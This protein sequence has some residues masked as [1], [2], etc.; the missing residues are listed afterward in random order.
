MNRSRTI[1]ELLGF[2]EQAEAKLLSWGFYD[3]SFSPSELEELVENEAPLELLEAVHQL[4]REGTEK[5][6][7]LL[8]EMQFGKLLFETSNR[9]RRF[10]TRFAESI[11]LLAQA[12]AVLQGGGLECR[13]APCLGPPSPYC[14]TSVSAPGPGV[15]RM[16][17]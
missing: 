2:V 15:R 9:P 7:D 8:S 4:T 16:L 17:G 1:A 5:F 14:A 6:D 3:I 11:R 13:R 12:A 10:R